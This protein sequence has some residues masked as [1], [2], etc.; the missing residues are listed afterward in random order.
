[1][2]Q[3]LISS[4]QVKLSEVPNPTPQVG[5]IMVQVEYS[6]LSAGTEMAGITSS[7]V[8]LW[9]KA[10][11]DPNKALQTIKSLDTS[12]EKIWQLVNKKKN[13]VLP[14]GYSAAGRVVSLG[15]GVK[16]FSVGD[17]IACS[18]SESAFHAEFI[19]VPENL[20]TKIPDKVPTKIASTVTMGA[21]AMQGI[22]RA[23][24]LLGET[25]VVIGLGLLG[26]LT[27][28]ILKAN[29]CRVIAI[30]LEKEK[31]SV[32]K[33]LGADCV[34]S[35]KQEIAAKFNTLINEH[36]G[37]YKKLV[38]LEQLINKELQ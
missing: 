24:P 7:A 37:N 8:P 36:K 9:K 21:I 17:R 23:S 18:G 20:C 32:A 15:K 11:K 38:E 14:T 13:Q 2:K 26:Q 22:R 33:D 31:L 16:G 35:E 4:G 5:E 6:C 19:S 25:F 29:G 27:T 10:Y 28:Q 30:D 12:P 34:A 3:V 1:M